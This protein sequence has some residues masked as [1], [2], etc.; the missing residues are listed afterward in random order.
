MKE[1]EDNESD[2]YLAS[3]KYRS[4]WIDVARVLAAYLIVCY[5]TPGLPDWTY[6]WS[7]G[8]RTA[9]F[10]I[11][12]GYFCRFDLPYGKMVHKA[13]WLLIPLLI[14]NVLAVVTQYGGAAGF[15]VK[16]LTGVGGF[17][18]YPAVVP[19]WFLFYIILYTLIVP[20]LRMTRRYCWVVLV[21]LLL[22]SANRWSL[23]ERSCLEEFFRGLFPFYLGLCL[24][25]YPLKELE[26]NLAKNGR[27]WGGMVLAVVAFLLF[28]VTLDVICS[29]VGALAIVSV[30]ALIDRYFGRVSRWVSRHAAQASFMVF[31]GHVMTYYILLAWIPMD[32]WRD[33]V[34]VAP[35]AVMFFWVCCYLVLERWCPWILPFLA[36]K[37]PVW[38]GWGKRTFSWKH[39][40]LWG[41]GGVGLMAVICHASNFFGNEAYSEW[42]EV[43]GGKAN[44]AAQWQVVDLDPEALQLAGMENGSCREI[45]FWIKNEKKGPV[46]VQWCMS[47]EGRVCV[48]AQYEWVDGERLEER[49]GFD[50]MKQL[51]ID[52]RPS[53][54]IR[55]YWMRWKPE[56]EADW[57]LLRLTLSF[58]DG[59]GKVTW[60]RTTGARGGEKVLSVLRVNTIR[61]DLIK[62]EVPVKL[63]SWGGEY[64]LKLEQ[65]LKSHSDGVAYVAFD[66][67][68]K[69][70]MYLDIYYAENGQYS[71]N[72]K[73]RVY[74]EKGRNRFLAPLVGKAQTD[75]QVRIK[76]ED[77][78]EA[79]IYAVYE[80]QEFDVSSRSG[81]NCL[82]GIVG[83]Q[84]GEVRTQE[85]SMGKRRD[86]L[87][88]THGNLVVDGENDLTCAAVER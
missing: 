49:E 40:A 61:E 81:L 64:S 87:T 84:A 48:K 80:I 85:S 14:W 70:K 1:H 55:K 4:A 63:E 51:D 42:N 65:A 72:R 77:S 67:E 60:H 76:P 35:L 3:S 74:G 20:L 36:H 12:A 57:L 83:K 88:Q 75:Y 68:A 45:E 17:S 28:G 5:H 41:I 25:A 62:K 27:Y 15:S 78:G 71:E 38:S 37:Q 82:G 26:G 58:P 13:V 53:D 33:V 10:F 44:V 7:L 8:G 86:L 11:L 43:R 50:M 9:L 34:W 21:G 29:M 6:G 47:G 56:M 31:A 32:I 54:G 30:A 2:T 73:I 24:S 23:F 69:R 16:A 22:V 52:Y 19:L 39:D 46:N 59:A 66:W 79:V 18:V